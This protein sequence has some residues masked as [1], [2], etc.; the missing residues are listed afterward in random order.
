MLYRRSPTVTERGSNYS[1]QFRFALS[2]FYV[3]SILLYSK[4]RAFHDHN[5]F[6][7]PGRVFS[8]IAEQF[9][10]LAGQRQVGLIY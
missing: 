9:K 5:E 6:Y 1:S 10:R 3:N 2:K 7:R 4:K 8:Q